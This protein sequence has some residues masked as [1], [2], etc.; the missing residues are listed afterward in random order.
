MQRRQEHLPFSRAKQ[1]ADC[2]RIRSTD[3]H[4]NHQWARTGTEDKIKE[5]LASKVFKILFFSGA[6]Y[7]FYWIES[8]TTLKQL[9]WLV[10]PDA[11]WA[12]SN[13][14]HSPSFYFPSLWS[15][16]LD[17]WCERM[18]SWA[19]RLSDCLIQSI[20]LPWISRTSAM[21]GHVIVTPWTTPKHWS[22]TLCGVWSELP[23]PNSND[24]TFGR[25]SL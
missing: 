23:L 13:T 17:V 25:R 21:F 20:H 18:S 11:H 10:S 8:Q 4:N 9:Y 5:D 12:F 24:K 2:H 22:L 6:K 16:H 19:V 15:H 7:F 14:C 3:A 1:P